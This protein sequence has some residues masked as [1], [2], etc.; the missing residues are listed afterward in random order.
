MRVNPTG[1]ST[2]DH[3]IKFENHGFSNGE[4][5]TYNYETSGITG[6]ST[7]ARY[8]ILKLDSDKFRLCY[9]G[10]DGTD[11]SNYQRQ[12][13]IKFSTTG[14]G[15]QIF[16]Y[17]DIALSIDYTSVGLGSTQVRGSIVATPII[18]G[19]IEQVYVYEKGSNYGSLVLNQHQRPQVIV[20]TVKNHSS[21]H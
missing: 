18:R 11:T 13:Y 4:I 9:A 19:N 8:Q 3:T 20:K 1:I 6:L 21:L 7:S 14:S 12:N 17:P 16:N 2:Y 5:V 15:Y 10:I